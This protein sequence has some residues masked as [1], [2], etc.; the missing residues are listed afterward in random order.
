[1]KRRVLEYDAR[2]RKEDEEA[3]RKAKEAEVGSIGKKF[4]AF[5]LG[6]FFVRE[7]FPNVFFT[8]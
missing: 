6:V 4:S 3:K 2:D 7:F 8:F 1:M 5:F